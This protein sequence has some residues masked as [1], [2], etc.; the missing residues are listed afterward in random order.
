MTAKKAAKAT[1]YGSGHV[2]VVAFDDWQWFTS[3]DADAVAAAVRRDVL[4][5]LRNFAHLYIVGLSG[6]TYM[7]F[8]AHRVS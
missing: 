2:L 1:R 4:P 7:P 5:T 3:A 8:A 6:R